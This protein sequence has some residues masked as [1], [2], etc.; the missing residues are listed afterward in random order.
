MTDPKKRSDWFLNIWSAIN[1]LF[2]KIKVLE[3]RVDK[4]EKELRSSEHW[5]KP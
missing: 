5:R 1:K 2:Q 4:L 3:D